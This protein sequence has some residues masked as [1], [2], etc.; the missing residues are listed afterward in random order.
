MLDQSNRC[1]NIDLTKALFHSNEPLF[2]LTKFLILADKLFCRFNDSVDLRG[3]ATFNWY[4]LIFLHFP[5]MLFFILYT[6]L[7]I[8]INFKGNLIFFL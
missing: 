8:C 4:I 2:V 3:F 7:S 5:K 6:F 1:I